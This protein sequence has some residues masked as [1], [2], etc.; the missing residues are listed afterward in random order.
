MS[1]QYW[2]YDHRIMWELNA[3][4]CVALT[5][6]VIP[7]PQSTFK[8]RISERSAK[9]AARKHERDAIVRA[10][11]LSADP[12]RR[13]GLDSSEV[14]VTT[15]ASGRDFLSRNYDYY[16]LYSM[17]QRYL[18]RAASPMPY[19]HHGRRP[20][21][22]AAEPAPRVL[23]GTGLT[24]VA[25]KVASRSSSP[26]PAHRSGGTTAA[27]GVSATDAVAEGEGGDLR[28]SDDTVRP[29][30][31]GKYHSAGKQNTSAA[32]TAGMT[33]R[34]LQPDAGGKYRTF[35]PSPRSAN[36]SPSPGG[37][38]SRPTSPGAESNATAH[39]SVTHVAKEAIEQRRALSRRKREQALEEFNRKHY[40]RK[41][42]VPS[43]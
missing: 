8:P 36:R 41:E 30:E 15:A 21:T 29:D 17:P 39:V 27:Q 24:R 26:V 31:G 33:D 25:E 28:L 9:L 20:A 16:E 38:F 13:R 34:T 40:L 5:H 14:Q 2:R 37:Y 32:T 12:H 4:R 10:R 43:K 23:E 6:Y 18:E 19:K 22:A 3:V 7:V 35:C 42:P 11:S 1:R